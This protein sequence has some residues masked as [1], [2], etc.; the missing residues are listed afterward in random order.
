MKTNPVAITFIVA[1]LSTLYFF[2]LVVSMY[3]ENIFLI[4]LNIYL[5]I[6]YF[7][8]FVFVIIPSIFVSLLGDF[9]R[10]K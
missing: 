9:F 4:K 1:A 8:V 3:T 2:T 7:G 6:L 10:R 5:N